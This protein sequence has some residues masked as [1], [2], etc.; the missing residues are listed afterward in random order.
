MY[1]AAGMMNGSASHPFAVAVIEGLQL[2]DVG[3][4]DDTHDLKLAILKKWGVIKSVE[5]RH[6][7]R[8]CTANTYLEALI[9]QD[10]LDSRILA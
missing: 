4:S 1:S 7:N 3:V 5:M 2:H 9:L 10:T 8:L 6:Q